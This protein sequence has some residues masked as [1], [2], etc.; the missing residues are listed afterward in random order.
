MALYNY[1]SF[2]NGLP[3]FWAGS[4]AN[5]ENNLI[6]S[7]G[8]MGLPVQR[9]SRSLHPRLINC[10]WRFTRSQFS[11][12]KNWWKTTLLGGVVPFTG[13]FT[14]NGETGRMDLQFI[15]DPSYDSLRGGDWNVTVKAWCW[16][17]P[18]MT[19]GEAL[20]EVI[21]KTFIENMATGIELALDSYYDLGNQ[22]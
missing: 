13:T 6:A 17:Y 2:P 9:Q 21:D 12:F 11:T 20:E 10:K 4:N 16:K 14:L 8:S 1:P 7:G 3:N 15:G 18:E 22:P 5:I 19:R